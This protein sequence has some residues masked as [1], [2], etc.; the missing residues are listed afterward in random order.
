MLRFTCTDLGRWGSRD[1]LR[2]RSKR[3]GAVHTRHT[4]GRQGR[5]KRLSAVTASVRDGRRHAGNHMQGG[6]GIKLGG[7]LFGL[8]IPRQHQLSHMTREDFDLEVYGHPNITN[9]Y[10]DHLAEHP[11]LKS[12]MMNATVALR[13]VVLLPRAPRRLAAPV[14]AQWLAVVQDVRAAL[15]AL[16]AADGT[17][18]M[19]SVEVHLC[20]LEASVLC[21]WVPSGKCVTSSA[22]GTSPAESSETAADLEECAAELY[23]AHCLLGQQLKP[24]TPAAGAATSPSG[25][26]TSRPPS[27]QRRSRPAAFMSAALRAPSLTSSRVTAPGAA[28]PASD[29]MAPAAA[30]SAPSFTSAML[31]QLL[32]EVD[33][34]TKLP[35][36]VGN[37]HACEGAEK[38]SSAASR[39]SSADCAAS[40]RGTAPSIAAPAGSGIAALV[41]ECSATEQPLLRLCLRPHWQPS[42]TLSGPRDGDDSSGTA[43]QHRGGDRS[44]AATPP[45]RVL[46][47]DIDPNSE[48]GVWRLAQTPL[49]ELLRWHYVAQ[50]PRAHSHDAL[51]HHRRRLPLLLVVDGSTTR[52]EGT[53]GGSGAGAAAAR[54]AAAARVAPA[55]PTLMPRRLSLELETAGFQMIAEASLQHVAESLQQWSPGR[56]WEQ[57]VQGHPTAA[58]GGGLCQDAAAPTTTTASAA[59]HAA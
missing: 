28:A 22:V 27:P 15:A 58:R 14:P 20:T 32:R 34:T 12:V 55:L 25:I 26:A 6:L 54:A 19:G 40:T 57:Y 1:F 53:D 38:P 35:T 7:G 49:A 29:S 10:R 24:V 5:Y 18:L 44:E 23:R 56:Q 39:A 9:P 21:N 52:A 48:A 13:L 45:R 51:P 8:R 3:A 31:A 50:D 36:E 4:H 2:G 16:T 46:K 17:A 41:R 42:A 43:H 59:A 47:A 37:T 30:R 33:P 11:D